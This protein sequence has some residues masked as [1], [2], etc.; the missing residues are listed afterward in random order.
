MTL[1]AGE[2]GLQEDGHDLLGERRADD[3]AADHNN[4]GVIVFDCLMG[5]VS[6][7]GERRTDS[8]DLVGGYGGSRPRSAYQYAAIGSI[9]SHCSS[10]RGRIVGVV[11]RRRRVR[12]H[13]EEGIALICNQFGQVF[14]ELEPSVVGSNSNSHVL[15]SVVVRLAEG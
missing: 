13:V 7:V 8:L 11:D 3:P 5:R 4:V 10:D 9:L 6:V 2:T 14:L 1:L 12:P 15:S